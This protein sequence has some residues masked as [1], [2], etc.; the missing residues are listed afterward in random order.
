MDGSDEIARRASVNRFRERRAALAGDLARLL[1][2]RAAV[3]PVADAGR[4][5][6]LLGEFDRAYDAA[7]AHEWARVSRWWGA[8]EAVGLADTL[9]R[10]ARNLGSRD[11]WL[12]LQGPEPQAVALTSDVA[13]DNPLG[14]AALGDHELRILDRHV[15]AGVWLLRHAYH[16][17]ADV[18]YRWELEVWGAEPWLSATTRA[19]RGIG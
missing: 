4:A 11:A 12:L 5:A 1:G 19:L 16:S 14:F 13:L 17:P 10:L 9:H 6:A 2:P 8:D 18:Q 3:D 7:Q 15:P